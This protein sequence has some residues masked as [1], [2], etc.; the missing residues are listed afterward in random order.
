MFF[1]AVAAAIIL[2]PS[3]AGAYAVSG[4]GDISSGGQVNLPQLPPNTFNLNWT[5]FVNTLPVQGF[6]NSLQ[7]AGT[8]AVQN[9]L[10]SAVPTGIDTSAGH[11]VLQQFDDWTSA[12][13]GFRISVVILAVLN[14]FSWIL[15]L[16]KTAVDWIIGFLK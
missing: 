12:H 7:S 15:A 3:V 8:T 9:S 4:G 2:M 6:I 16:M 1:S 5:N 13:L 11:A 14:V 10:E